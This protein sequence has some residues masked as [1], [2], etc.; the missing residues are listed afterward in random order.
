MG[1]K[2]EGY[3]VAIVGRPNVG[4]SALFNRIVGT[5]AAIVHEESG[6]TRD[7]LYGKR[8]W[9]GR[10]LTVL[11]T[12]G[13]DPQSDDDLMKAIRAQVEQAIR[14]A[15]GL[16][17]VVDGKAGLMPEDSDI[18]DIL[19]KTRKPVVLAVNKCDAPSH[20]SRALEFYQLGFEK[21]F[22]VSAA[23][24]IGVSDLLDSIV[25]ML[26]RQRETS[27]GGPEPV[28]QPEAGADTIAVAI[29]GKPN[30]GK[31]SLVNALLRDERM[32][33]S[34]VP[35]TTVDAV[36]TP[37]VWDGTQFVLIDTAGL[38]RPKVIE[39]ELEELAVRKALRAVKR[40]DVA[41][42]VIDGTGA[43][44]AQE[45]RISGY[46]HRNG[47]ASVI[48]VNKVDLGLYDGVMRQQYREAVKYVCSPI[49][50]SNVL[51]ASCVTGEGIGK[52]LA[53][54]RRAYSEYSKRIDTSV[55][56]QVLHEVT[57]LNK[58]PKGAKIYYGT[59]VEIRPPRM[60]FF[61]K[62]PD[63]ITAPYQRYLES[64]LRKYF[65]FTGSPLIMEFRE[66][67]RKQ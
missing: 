54:V 45:R 61:V 27:A 34:P 50:Y 64:E 46:I 10:Q 25:E 32:T 9:K 1:E 49:G 18:A 60:V 47:K 7:R 51:F 19:R 13:L 56:N 8:L 66:R 41:I 53:E 12:G 43:P 65:D 2:K 48:V 17:F 59:Q 3:V 37:F 67:Q 4:K 38:R 16:I 14:E 36:D 20:E 22:P 6:V 15:S 62:N 40:A 63:D 11:D 28:G 5:S 55:L 24:G 58:P 30:V 44:S 31:S 42:L 52:I 39:R 21:V 57:E 35:G 33:V 26:D 23:H 29:V